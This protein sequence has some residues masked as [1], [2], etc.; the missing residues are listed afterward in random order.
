MLMFY[1]RV[2]VLL[3]PPPPKMVGTS[4]IRLD[5]LPRWLKLLTKLTA[6]LDLERQSRLARTPLP[7]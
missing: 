3:G 5:G 4:G 2:G 1:S 7:G 6:I